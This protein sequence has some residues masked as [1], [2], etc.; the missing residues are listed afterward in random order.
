MLI[1][2]SDIPKKNWKKVLTPAG[3]RTPVLWVPPIRVNHKAK[4]LIFLKKSIWVSNWRKFRGKPEF[5][6]KY[7]WKSIF[8]GKWTK[9]SIF[10]CEFSFS[11]SKRLPCQF[12]KHKQCKQNSTKIL[13]PS[14]IRAPA[15]WVPAN[16]VS[17]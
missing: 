17:H 7:F 13:T 3:V 8:F 9:I 2:I 14:G 1:K 6:C 11:K 12:S 15:L 4:N 5:L 10:F 16:S